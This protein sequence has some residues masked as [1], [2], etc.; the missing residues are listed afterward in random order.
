MTRGVRSEAQQLVHFIRRLE[1]DQPQ[2]PLPPPLPPGRIVDVA[3]RGEMFVREREGPASGVNVVLVHG[4]ALSADLNWFPGSYEVAARYGRVI[5]PD[6]R[7]HGRGLRSE[8]PFSLEAAADDIAALIDSVGAAP[9]VIVGYSMGGSLAMLC[10]ARH[11]DLVGGLVLASTG[12]QWRATWWERVM[13]ASMAVVEYG[14]RF[15]APKGLTERYLRSAVEQS[16]D[17]QRYKGWVKAEV[18]R[19]DPSDIGNAGKSLARFDAREL[20]QE[21]NVPTAVIVTCLDRLI[22]SDRQRQLAVATSAQVIEIEGAHNAW[23]IRPK[24]FSAA[25]DQGLEYVLMHQK[26]TGRSGF[27]HRFVPSKSSFSVRPG[28]LSIF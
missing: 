25:I 5:A 18:R 16:P 7:G 3:G 12:L 22:R 6:V 1:K 10:A 17:L 13:W 20:A 11:P 15:G 4:W 19:G 24:E 26:R 8:K 2:D 9:A 21:I 14:L 28:R 23:L 27:G